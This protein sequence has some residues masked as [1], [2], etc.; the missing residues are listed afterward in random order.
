M[1]ETKGAK[2]D[3]SAS[4][5]VTFKDGE[6]GNGAFG[7]WYAARALSRTDISPTRHCSF[8]RRICMGG[9]VIYEF[10]KGN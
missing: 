3:C 6:M 4:V 9:G 7:A 1:W 10:S 2:I 8:P 5:Q